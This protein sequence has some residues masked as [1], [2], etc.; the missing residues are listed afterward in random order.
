M[1]R[2]GV[3]NTLLNRTL[4][5]KKIGASAGVNKRI[6]EVTGRGPRLDSTFLGLESLQ[7]I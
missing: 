7:R 5:E 2:R 1:E 6:I 3:L 4:L